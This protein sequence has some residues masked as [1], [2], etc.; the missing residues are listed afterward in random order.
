[1]RSV[2]EWAV[3]MEY[4]ADNLCDRVRPVLGPQNQAVKH[5]KA[6]PHRKVGSAIR[7]ARTTD[8]MPVARLAFEF[9]VP[10]TARCVGPSG[11]KSI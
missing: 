6:L 3:A 7:K 10:T 9:L 2:F 8:G 4:R 11:R 5:M 1:M